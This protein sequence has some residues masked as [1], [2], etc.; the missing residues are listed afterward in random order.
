MNTKHTIILSPSLYNSDL[1]QLRDTLL[2]LENANISH[3]H[4]DVMDSHFVPSFGFSANFVANLK[5]Q[6]SLFLDC[7]LMV[8]KPEDRMMPFIDAGADR[9]TFHA[10]AT[11]HHF[12]IINQLRKHRV[13]VGIA[14]NPGTSVDSIKMLLPYLDLVLV[15]TVNPG[16]SGETFIPLSIEKISALH[17]LK[18]QFSYDYDIQVDGNITN[19]TI[20]DCVTHGA[21]HIVS[22]G[23]IFQDDK[24]EH[25]IS[26]LFS[27][28]KNSQ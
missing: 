2:R 1:C 26:T 24:I 16:R 17:Q 15:M 7:H 6:T 4:I 21:N 27:L 23:F 11:N 20:V 10:E 8:E 9:I 5:K 19:E 12:V 3:L 28:I 18:Q 13:N 14:I 22:G 25:H